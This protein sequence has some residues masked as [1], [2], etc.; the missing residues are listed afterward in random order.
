MNILNILYFSPE[1]GGGIVKHLFALGRVSKSKGYNLVFG[2]TKTR[3]WQVELQANSE[4]LIIPE[5][6]NPFRSGFRKKL[7][8]I[9]E[10]H[11]TDIVHFHFL[12]AMPFSLS[13]SFRKWG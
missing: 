9:C 3:E 8:K 10:S 5:I 1:V 2:F 11:S 4:V 7:Q 12:F 6:E 13:L